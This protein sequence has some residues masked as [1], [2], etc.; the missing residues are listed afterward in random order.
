MSVEFIGMI[1]TQPARRFI[2][3]ADPRSISTTCA[4]SRRRTSSRVSIAY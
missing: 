2:R 3:R 4:A 1:G